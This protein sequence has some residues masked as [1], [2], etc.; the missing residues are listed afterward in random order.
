ML[1]WNLTKVAVSH[2]LSEILTLLKLVFGYSY[3]EERK[4]SKRSEVKDKIK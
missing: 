3:D 2:G 1:I 4:L